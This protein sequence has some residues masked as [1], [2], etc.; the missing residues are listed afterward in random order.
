MEFVICLRVV[1]KL[2]TEITERTE[3][4]KYLSVFEKAD[5]K[6]RGVSSFSYLLY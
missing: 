6:I 3:I 1:S 5:N 2:L 4:A